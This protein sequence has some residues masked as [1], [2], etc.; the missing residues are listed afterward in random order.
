[1]DREDIQK[2]QDRYN[3]SDEERLLTRLSVTSQ[4]SDINQSRVVSELVLGKKIERATDKIVASNEKLSASN[5]KHSRA[6]VRLTWALVFVGIIQI[7]IQVVQIVRA[8]IV[9]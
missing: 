5:E 7:I 9:Q 4:T 2:I 3:F 6:M 1:M 8:G